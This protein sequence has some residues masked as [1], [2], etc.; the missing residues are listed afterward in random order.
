MALCA[1]SKK[2]AL[3]E[4]GIIM[5]RFTARKRLALDGRVW[6]CIYDNKSCKWSSYVCFGK[7]KT[8]KAANA[9]IS[10]FSR[11]CNLF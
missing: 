2:T 9:A 6:W 5:E 7:Y 8:K 11:V 10:Y 1:S 4:G 3:F